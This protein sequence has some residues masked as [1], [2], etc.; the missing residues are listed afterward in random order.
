MTR[1]HE[2]STLAIDGGGTRCRFALT[3]GEESHVVQGGSVNVS[4]DFEAATAE[5]LHGIERVAARSGYS[6]DEIADTPAYLGLAGV[7]GPKV[8]NRLMSRLPFRRVRI[9]DDRRSALRGA[10]GDSDG[11]VAHCG[12]GSFAA[13]RIDGRMRFSGGWGPVLGDEAS[14]Q[15]VG[16][17]ALSLTLET[18]DGFLEA[19]DLVGILLERF[20]GSSEIVAFAG[21][22][23]PAEFGA[24]AKDVTRSAANGDVIARRILQDAA[25]CIADTARKLSW[26]AGLPICLTGGIGPHYEDYLPEDMRAVVA[27]ALGEP[28]TGAIALAKDFRKEIANERR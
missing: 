16:R 9:E 8:V 11:V 14:A 17:R 25:D 19:T 21:T 13:A 2:T 10:L 27:P 6:T 26:N 15:W 23:S 24:L 22:A 28:L 7:T 5:L 18:V 20:G 4:T 3:S 1:T 12:T